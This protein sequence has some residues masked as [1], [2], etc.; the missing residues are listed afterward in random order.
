MFKKLP[1]LLTLGEVQKLTNRSRR[2]LQKDVKAGL[3]R[4]TRLGALVR[5]AEGDYLAYIEHG[6]A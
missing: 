6:R 2:S 4:V 1:R 3:L 5:V